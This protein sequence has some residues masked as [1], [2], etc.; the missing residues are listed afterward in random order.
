MTSCT[1]MQACR[2]DPLP[3]NR[4]KSLWT[5][6]KLHTTHYRQHGF[7]LKG[8]AHVRML[9]IRSPKFLLQLYYTSTIMNPN[10]LLVSAMINNFSKCIVHVHLI[11]VVQA[12]FLRFNFVMTRPYLQKMHSSQS[13]ARQPSQC[14]QRKRFR[15]C[16]KWCKYTNVPKHS[17]IGNC[18]LQ[19]KDQNKFLNYL[20]TF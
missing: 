9:N 18:S 12:G 19:R 14:P 4:I 16:R 13:F 6:Q 10:S 1:Y 8:V 5:N 2:N 11:P 3:P 7:S 20:W 15:L 17:Q